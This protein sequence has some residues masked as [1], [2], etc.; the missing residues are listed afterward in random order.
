VAPQNQQ[1]Q[2]RET[3]VPSRRRFFRQM[4]TLGLGAGSLAGMAPAIAADWQNWSGGQKATP[5]NI[6]FP[7]SEAEL[8][9]LVK[10]AAG[11][12]RAFGGGHSFSPVA[13][14][15]GTMISLEQ[16][17]GIVSHDASALTATIRAGSRI[18]SLGDPLKAI[19]QGL[20]NEADINMQSLGGAIST[21]TH[22]T[23]RHLQ[24]YSATVRRL[25]VVLAD[26]SIVDCSANKD[27]ELFEA[28]RV[29]VGSL[30]IFSEI[31]LQNRAAYKLRAIT[32][33]MNTEDALTTLQ[34]ERDQH[35][36][37][38]FFA[39][40][41]GD[42][43]IVK[44]TEITNDAPTPPLKPGF[45]ENEILEWAA[46]TARLHP[47]SNRWLQRAVGLFVSDSTVVGDSFNI[48]PSPRN[49]QFNEM[50]YSL[51]A[52]QGMACFTE[53][54]DTIR[55]QNVNVFFPIEFRYVAADECWLS[56]FYQRDTVSISVHQFF[57]QDYREFFG[58]AEP[59]LRKYGGRPHWGKLHT[60]K[61]KE[62]RALYPRFDDFVKIRNRADPQ[63]KFLSPYARTLFVS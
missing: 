43:A 25:R 63:G 15:Q 18:A 1:E 56:P 54:R 52:E 5:Q 37:I 13:L 2:E 42:K 9:T 55:R 7:G 24:C 16:L 36:H 39:F 41:Y 60:L 30:G 21:A 8:A 53:L 19:G 48:Y 32:T 26:G 23:G 61:A 4:A 20:L 47:W 44:R 57:K 12:V 29:A 31:T 3:M 45:D 51:P 38:E 6:A 35:R 14:S 11:P 34:K 10:N 28:A 62:L 33:V 27:N 49:V 50:E 17:N 22:G 59:I 40:P 58:I 46:D